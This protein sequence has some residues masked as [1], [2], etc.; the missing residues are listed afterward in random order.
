[1]IVPEGTPRSPGRLLDALLDV[2]FPIRC[3]GCGRRG[4][5]VCEA[6]WP[7]IAWLG[8]E[9]CPRCASPARLGRICRRC[10]EG[11]LS[12]DGALA[13]CRFEGVVRTAVHDLKFKGVRRRAELLGALVGEAI[14]R[15]PLAIDLLVPIPLGAARRRQ[16]GFNQSELIANAVGA[17]LGVPV[18]ASCLERVKETQPQVRQSQADRRANVAGAFGCREPEAAAGRRIGLV[19]DVMTTGS[20]LSSAAE[21]LK[22]HGAARVYAVV[23]AREV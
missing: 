3:A 7:S 22:A 4:V 23:V 18:V 16:R 11:D 9:V 15:R 13:A 10:S 12:L 20:T 19:D 14:E 6:C 5:N 8:A 2:L 1:V 17:R 21:I